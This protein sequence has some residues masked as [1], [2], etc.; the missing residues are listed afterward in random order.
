[1]SEQDKGE[2]DMNGEKTR[3]QKR[4]IKEADLGGSNNRISP[5]DVRIPGRQTAGEHLLTEKVFERDKHVVHV[6]RQKE[7]PEKNRID[8]G[9]HHERERNQPNSRSFHTSQM[10]S[11]MIALLIFDCPLRRSVKIMGISMIRNFFLVA[12]KRVAI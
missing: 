3:E 5:G 6:A 4:G 7:F 2:V 12:R 10:P 11:H 8:R 9:A 1:M